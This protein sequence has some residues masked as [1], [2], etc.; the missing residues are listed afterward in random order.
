[1]IPVALIP[2]T[3]LMIL[4]TA[5]AGMSSATLLESPDATGPDEQAIESEPRPEFEGH[6]EGAIEIPAMSLNVLVDLHHDGSFWTGT[7]DIPAQGAAGIGLS[8]IR[9]AGME[10]DF[11]IDG[12]PG[13]PTFAGTLEDGAI[14]GTFNQYGQGFPF[15]LGREAIEAARRP[16]E[17]KPPYPYLEE[18][19]SYTHGDVTL[20]GTLTTPAGDGPHPAVLLI[21]GSGPQNRDEE[22][23]GH[24]PFL[25]LSDHLTRRGI[26]VLRVDDRGVGESTGDAEQAT[27]EDFADDA[28][29]G[30]EFLL[31]RPEID[32]GRIGL[33]GHSEGGVIAPMVASR[34]DD[35]SFIILLAGTGVPGDEIIL[36][37]MELIGR[38]SGMEEERIADVIGT[39]RQ[40]LDLV[41]A[42]AT[43]AELEAMLRELVVVQMGTNLT[44]EQLDDAAR[45]HAQ[46]ATSPWFRFFLGYD[47]RPILEETRIPV[48]ALGGEL[49]LQVDPEQNLQ[50][51]RE[52]LRK[53]GNPDYT[54]LELPG[55]NHLFQSAET[56]N[57]DEYYSID[58]TF[59]PAA[60]D[61]VSDWILKRFANTPE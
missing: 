1:M 46:I 55:L 29:A 49:D 14:E 54:V 30:V 57:P 35:V 34:S 20:A 32:P 10:I 31:A 39:Q 47:P 44:A 2:V 12:V 17:P 23:F 61:T 19:V 50:E 40:M 60:L 56:G 6:W 21:S 41:R 11:M 38:A 13:E 42:K 25:V 26:A 58:E 8:G 33:I 4:C 3:L 59:S 53:A 48:L 5:P 15:R 45:A 43:K 36:R 7:I 9:V 16:Q 28:M 52:A 51:I 22:V 18:E 24:R 27:S 37:Q